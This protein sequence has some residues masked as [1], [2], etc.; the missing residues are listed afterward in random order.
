[1]GTQSFDEL[2]GA[3]GWKDSDV[4]GER[5]SGVVE[6]AA[7]EVKN[8]RPVKATRIGLHDGQ[9]V[10]LGEIETEIVQGMFREV[11]PGAGF[12]WPRIEWKWCVENSREKGRET[13]R[14][15]IERKKRS[16]SR[17]LVAYDNDYDD[18]P[19][20]TELAATSPIEPFRETT[21]FVLSTTKVA[22]GWRH[23]LRIKPSE[24]HMDRR[25]NTI[26]P[27]LK[28]YR[29]ELERSA[30]TQIKNLATRVAGMKKADA[31]A[32]MASLEKLGPSFFLA[33]YIEELD[34]QSKF[35]D[36]SRGCSTE[37]IGQPAFRTAA[38]R[39]AYAIEHFGREFLEYDFWEGRPDVQTA[40]LP[41]MLFPRAFRGP[42]GEH[43][44]ART[45]GEFVYVYGIVDH[46][47]ECLDALLSMTEARDRIIK[48]GMTTEKMGGAFNREAAEESA[49]FNWRVACEMA[50]AG[51]R[52]IAEWEPTPN[53]DVTK[54]RP[55][56]DLVRQHFKTLTNESGRR[57]VKRRREQSLDGAGED[58]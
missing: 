16:A 57:G 1:M 14:A 52:A 17:T 40:G 12:G 45:Q 18:V 35:A 15:S 19:P 29:D 39:S 7:D 42:D 44:H 47:D 37:G 4:S 8:P 33:R 26:W 5:F 46:Y 34:G 53:G 20:W 22:D 27:I 11:A 9:P 54:Y 50:L 31:L 38:E 25:A 3:V 23:A 30:D 6:I 21:R 58:S 41:S 24:R 36:E 51:P 48:E 49:V 2:L 43:K 56:V 13:R 28:K 55:I 10:V 32:I